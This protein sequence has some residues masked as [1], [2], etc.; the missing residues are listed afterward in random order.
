[1]KCQCSY[2]ETMVSKDICMSNV[3]PKRLRS[4]RG[5]VVKLLAF[6]ARGR[7]FDPGL[8]QSFG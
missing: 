2:H 8:L 1:M 4:L 7:E 3:I 6:L 5:V